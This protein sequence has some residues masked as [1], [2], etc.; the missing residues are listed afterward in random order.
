MATAREYAQW[1]VD[2]QDLAGTENFQIVASAYERAKQRGRAPTAPEETIFRRPPPETSFLGEAARSA[3][4]LASSVRT[5]LGSLLGEE[6]A[7]AAAEAGLERQQAIAERYGAAPSFQDYVQTYREDGLLPAIGEAISDVPE[8]ISS[9]VPVITSLVAGSRLG[10]MAGAPFGPVG[11]TIGGIGGGFLALFPQFYGANVERQAQV[12][13]ERG[14][15]VDIDRARAAAGAAAQS[16]FESVGTGVILGKNLVKKVLGLADEAGD[17]AIQTNRARQQLLERSERSLAG[18]AGRTAARGATAEVPVE[19]AQQVVERYQADLDILSDDALQE[20]GDAAY[21]ALVVGGG[22]AGPRG[23]VETLGARREFRR[24]EE[25]AQAEQRA[26]QEAITGAVVEARTAEQ[27]AEAMVA[28]LRAVDERLRAE[29]RAAEQADTLRSTTVI[30]NTVAD[31]KAWGRTVLGIGPSADIIK[32]D[33]ALAGKDISDPAQA[34]EVRSILEAYASAPKR[35]SSII[36]KI[37]GYLQRPEFA[38]VAAPEEV[39]A[40]EEVVTEE[41][42]GGNVNQQARP[43]EEVFVTNDRQAKGMTPNQYDYLNTEVPG[44]PN[45]FRDEKGIAAE[46]VQMSPQEYLEQASQIFRGSGEAP[47]S[48]VESLRESRAEGVQ[49]IVDAINNGET[50]ASPYLDYK[51]GNQEGITRALAAEQLG[52]ETIPVTLI[53]DAKAATDATTEAE[54]PDEMTADDFAV[55]D[56]LSGLY[57]RSRQ[58]NNQ[59]EEDYI[60]KNFG[61]DVA[62]ELASIKNPDKRVEF[63]DEFLTAEQ[64][65]EMQEAMVD[66]ERVRQFSLYVGQFDESS[67]EKMGESIGLWFKDV[68]NKNF[69]ETPQYGGIV[70]AINYA[71]EMGWDMGRVLAGAK[72]KASSW[73]GT[74]AQELFPRLFQSAPVA[75]EVTAAAKTKGQGVVAAPPTEPTT[76]FVALENEPQVDRRTTAYLESLR[77]VDTTVAKGKSAT[78]EQTVA[79]YMKRFTPGSALQ[80]LAAEAAPKFTEREVAGTQEEA[81]EAL[82]WLIPKLSK[83]GQAVVARTERNVET[84]KNNIQRYKERAKRYAEQREQLKEERILTKKEARKASKTLSK[85]VKELRVAQIMEQNPDISKEDAVKLYRIEQREYR[86]LA[87]TKD[88]DVDENDKLARLLEA[89]IN[90]N[91]PEIGGQIPMGKER[92]RN[93]VANDVER[94]ISNGGKVKELPSVRDPD[95]KK[96]TIGAPIYKGKSFNQETA[97]LIRKGNVN[98]IITALMYK[99]AAEPAKLLR[100]VRNLGINPTIIVAELP[101]GRSGQYDAGTDTITISP[102]FGMNEQ[103]ILHELGHAALARGIANPN[104]KISKDFVR[105][106]EQLKG[107]LGDAYGG[108]NLQEFAAEYIGNPEFQA[109]LKTIKA[110]RS[111]NYFVNI[112]QAIAE[113][114]GFRTADKAAY[115]FISDL[116]DVSPDVNPRIGDVFAMATPAAQVD[117][118]SKIEQFGREVT[119]SSLRKTNNVLDGIADFGYKKKAYGLLR[120]DNVK[121]LWGQRLAAAKARGEPNPTLQTAYDTL[122]DLIA[123]LE[124][125][126]GAEEKMR[127][128]LNKKYE[129]FE[130]IQKKHPEATERLGKLAQDIR[131]ARI[132]FNKAN[133]TPFAKNPE[134][135][136]LKARLDALPK[137]VR[138]MYIEMRNDFDSMYEQFKAFVAKVDKDNNQKGKLLEEFLNDVPVEGYVPFT[139]FGDFAVDIKRNGKREVYPFE[140]SRARDEFIKAEGLKAAEEGAGIADIANGQY[141]AYER[142]RQ[143]RYDVTVPS[144][145]FLTRL[146]DSLPADADPEAQQAYRDAIFQTYLS[147]YPAGSLNK[148][149]MKAAELEGASTDLVRTYADTTIKWSRK[150]P[151]TEYMQPIDNAIKYFRPEEL[152][153]KGVTDPDILAFAAN[154]QDRQNFIRNPSYNPITTRLTTASFGMFILGSVA[155]A[156]VNLSVLPMLVFPTLAA[157]FGY[158]NATAAMNQA[159][160]VV[161]KSISDANWG[162]TG[163]DWGTGTKYENLFNTLQDHGQLEHTLA[164]EVMEGARM[165]TE[166]YSSMSAKIMNLLAV[167]FSATER[168]NRAFTAVS[169]Y[170]LAKRDGMS[171]ANAV[172]FALKTVKDMNT[173][174]THTTAAPLMQTD[175]GRVFFTFKSFNIN[176]AYVIGRAWKNAVAGEDPQLVAMARRQL[177]GIY[178]MSGAIAG[179]AGLPFM[180]SVAFLANLLVPDDEDEPF[181]LKEEMRLAVGELAY[182]GPLSYL[183]NLDI[184]SRVALAN[185]LVFRDDPRGVAEA[186]YMR[187]ALMT[188]FGPMGSAAINFE[189]GTNEIADGNIYRGVEY[190]MPTFVRNFMRGGRYMVDGGVMT[191]NGDVITTDISAYS[192]VMQMAGFAPTNL[193]DLYERRAFASRREEFLNAK[194]TQYLTEIFAA[195]QA[196]DLQGEIEARRRLQEFGRRNPGLIDENTISRSINAKEARLREDLNGLRLSPVGERIARERYGLGED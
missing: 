88:T 191:L 127:K 114:F 51:T 130:A 145:V 90:M 25:A 1:I 121:D 173:S 24:G 196:N 147:V 151:Q 171:E 123:Q 76:Q 23:A 84:I 7:A 159:R 117:A 91:N 175:M 42:A 53:N 144:S 116:L 193:S 54:S 89:K 92:E 105:F 167:P 47:N 108:Q 136:K 152:G 77:D 98:E 14:E 21:A 4:S 81:Q 137:P 186:G 107:Q 185:D 184:G 104:L 50:F 153:K 2:N 39:T 172:Q 6:E 86:I 131:R 40:P 126:L 60:R 110:P 93:D 9:Q 146:M 120:Y 129:K 36:A 148:N 82:S 192:K 138:D 18:G 29:A 85:A 101:E 38:P 188:A 195:R 71:N 64:E 72:R 32:A 87:G 160:K 58:R 94:Y 15:E 69:K 143:P 182:R 73:A 187:T 177:L 96:Q 62:N 80:V 61:D 194:K 75:E 65:K 125:R 162:M 176:S 33:G 168:Y 49:G 8:F 141:I 135:A 59:V 134:Y 161:G 115:K 57:E 41:V 102:Q 133:Q 95:W 165:R 12:Q 154:I 180:G 78:V 10:A 174:G 56:D 156:V 35:S 79:K 43:V 11:A 178:A 170:E 17:A 142:G 124:L 48:T 31:L 28:P 63:T 44:K 45:Y 67:P 181:D 119:K 128:A 140:S 34:A 113:F 111:D 155:S 3:E 26:E 99:Q 66:E 37:E 183:T 163:G 19:I 106:F 22:L 139:R 190:M 70:S 68:D 109:L 118:M 46:V 132:S 169:A 179:T 74:D 103:T 150:M 100:K 112:M 55:Y 52:Y 122:S 157:R 166:D 5:G 30:P 20:Y 97:D 83:R 158:T 16:A 27:E 189:R 164:R 149:F 13:I